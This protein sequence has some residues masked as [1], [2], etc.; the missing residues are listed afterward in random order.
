MKISL[1]IP[2][3]NRAPVLAAT[4]ETLSLQD[5]AAPFEVLVCD[6]GSD[7]ATPDVVAHLAARMPYRLRYL[8]QK[9][10]GARRAAA[11]NLG[12]AAAEAASL[13]VFIDDD[14]L[15]PPQFLRLHAAY[16]VRPDLATIGYRYLLEPGRGLGLGFQ[17]EFDRRPRMQNASLDFDRPWMSAATCNLGIDR[18]LLDRSGGFDEGFVGWGVE[19]T[20]F[21]YRLHLLGGELVLCREIWGWH[22]YDTSPT[23]PVHMLYRGKL[24]DY[25]SQI[26][27]LE[28]FRDKYPD[29]QEIQDYVAVR[30]AQTLEMQA[31]LAQHPAFR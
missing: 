20:E 24:P 1:V 15:V 19:D 14:M 25:S 23:N 28:Y 16:H 22:Q 8:R 31:N 17:I 3:Y 18:A 29:V 30:L 6:D 21:A 26:R 12:V 2:T 4:L 11:R 5:Y 7:D 9:R 13:V 10:N 27:N